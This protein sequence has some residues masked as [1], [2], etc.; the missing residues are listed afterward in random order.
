MFVSPADAA[1]GLTEMTSICE[2][3]MDPGF[4]NI[5]VQEIC[6]RFVKKLIKTARAC[7]TSSLLCQTFS[8]RGIVMMI[9]RL[10]HNLRFDNCSSCSIRDRLPHNLMSG[11]HLGAI[12]DHFKPCANW[13][14][15]FL[16]PTNH[17]SWNRCDNDCLGCGC[18]ST[19]SHLF[20]EMTHKLVL[21]PFQIHLVQWIR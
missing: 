9:R 11:E 18:L 17:R 13:N 6:Y 7:A 2:S 20:N 19:F 8:S 12:R 14:S 16:P 10:S 3:S 5:C 21:D 15:T 1:C 4:I